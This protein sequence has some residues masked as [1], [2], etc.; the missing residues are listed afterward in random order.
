MRLNK[1][2]VI[3]YLRDDAVGRA[4]PTRAIHGTMDRLKELLDDKCMGL[5][6]E[7]VALDSESTYATRAGIIALSLMR[8]ECSIM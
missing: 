1:C 4:V 8:D 2:R 7:I 3:A 5:I 6:Y